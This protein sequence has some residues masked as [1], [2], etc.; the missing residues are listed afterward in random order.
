MI[1][2]IFKNAISNLIETIIKT[3]KQFLFLYYHT[4]VH[5]NAMHSCGFL[6]W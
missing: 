2:S 6:K 1:L 3:D 4:K 5:L